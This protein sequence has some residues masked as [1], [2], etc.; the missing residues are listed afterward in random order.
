MLSDNGSILKLDSNSSELLLF[1]IPVQ[2]Q[3]GILY[4]RLEIGINF[5]D[6]HPVLKISPQSGMLSHPWIDPISQHLSY[7]PGIVNWNLNSSLSRLCKEA[8][9]EFSLN[10]PLA[11][12]T[13][14]KP[15]DNYNFN[16]NSKTSILPVFTTPVYFI[17]F[18]YSFM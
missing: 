8:I 3:Y 2:N 7:Q 16:N 17:F 10:P 6:R 13:N 14:I 1:D 12:T 15:V 9:E 18:K 11:L 4:L 5:P